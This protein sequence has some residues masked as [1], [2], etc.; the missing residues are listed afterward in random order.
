MDSKVK[1]EVGQAVEMEMKN[2]GIILNYPSKIEALDRSSLQVATPMWAGRPVALAT[3]QPVTVY[4]RLDRKAWSFTSEVVGKRQGQ[5]KPVTV[6]KQPKLIQEIGQRR[7][8]PL[9][10]QITPGRLSILDDR[11]GATTSN[12]AVIRRISGSEVTL[13]SPDS[14]DVGTNIKIEINLPNSQTPIKAMG[15]VM[16]VRPERVQGEFVFNMRVILVRIS[17]PD[18]EVIIRYVLQG[19]SAALRQQKLT[20]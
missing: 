17:L 2:G 4:F 1:L 3:G 10:V 9:D 6:L 15:Q 11:V 14:L 20:G 5:E 13:S 18:R 8:F 19:Q 7:Y 16:S 12:K